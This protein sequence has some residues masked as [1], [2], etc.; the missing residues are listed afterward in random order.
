[1]DYPQPAI[2]KRNYQWAVTTAGVS[3]YL[4]IS[5]LKVRYLI[6]ADLITPIIFG[7]KF[8]FLTDE[9]DAVNK[10]IRNFNWPNLSRGRR[11]NTRS[12]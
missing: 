5:K 4:Q 10:Y 3:K 6:D 8:I 12:H 7:S 1:V 11:N 9:L 2:T